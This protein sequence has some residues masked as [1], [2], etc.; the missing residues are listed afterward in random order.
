MVRVKCVFF[1]SFRETFETFS[2]DDTWNSFHTA[3]EIPSEY[4]LTFRENILYY[5]SS[6]F[7]SQSLLSS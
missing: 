7:E 1:C 2:S 3:E 4:T 5:L 6:Y